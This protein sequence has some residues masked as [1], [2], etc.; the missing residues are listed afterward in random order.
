MSREGER[1]GLRER[2]KQETRIALSW[3]A[4]RLAVE[5][6]LE[7]VRVEDIAAEARVAPRT[8]NNYFSSKGEAIAARHLDRARLIAQELRRRPASESLWEAIKIAVVT[9]LAM[10]AEYDARQPD[11]Q[12]Q[13]GIRLMISEPSLQGEML[14]ADA[15]AEDELA[16][17]IAERTGTDVARDLYPRLVAGAAGAA[18]R[19]AMDHW[20]R[21]DP[22]VPVKPLIEDA[23]DRLSAGLP[24]P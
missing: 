11:Q 12:W 5:R 7:N 3:A 15:I 19:V 23:L 24:E 20:L 21:S 8:F 6:G 14:K 16:A 18:I 1:P 4:I 22:P 2:K 13:T 17:A 10:G 9:Q